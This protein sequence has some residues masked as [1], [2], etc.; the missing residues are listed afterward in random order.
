MQPEEPY[1]DPTPGPDPRGESAGPDEWRPGEGW[2][3]RESGA[4]PPDRLVRLAAIFYGLLLLAAVVWRIG[5]DG[6]SLLY[7]TPEAAAAGLRPWR[8][9]GAGLGAG[10]GLVAASRYWTRRSAAAT[11][12]AA[13]LR[14]LLGRLPLSSVLLLALLSGVAEEAFFRGALQPR[15]GLVAASVLFGLAH[16]VPRRGLAVW[17]PAAAVAGLLLGALFEWT[18]NLVAPVVA[19]AVV[20]AMNLRWLSRAESPAP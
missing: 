20:N 11:A 17:A 12:L 3:P 9:L 18:G 4:P 10:L 8:D 16:F 13:S 14:E 2:R 6:G 15:V 19:H 7:R 5:I 1:R